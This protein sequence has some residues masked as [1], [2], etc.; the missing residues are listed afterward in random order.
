MLSGQPQ[1][2]HLAHLPG[3][4]HIG[5]LRRAG[6]ASLGSSCVTVPSFHGPYGVP[7]QDVG[8]LSVTRALAHMDVWLVPGRA[9]K[10]D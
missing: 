1:R 8:K 3:C 9:E 7:G 5:G 2:V 10:Y 4:G 6:T